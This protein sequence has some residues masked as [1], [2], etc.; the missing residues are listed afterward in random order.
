MKIKKS[1]KKILIILGIVVFALAAS[2]AFYFLFIRKSQEERWYD[3]NWSYRRSIYIKDIP[4]EFQETQQD[5][6]VQIDTETLISEEKL[7]NDCRDIRFIDEDNNTSLRYWIEGGCNTDETQVWVNLEL[8]KASEKIIYMYYGN[9]LAVDNQEGWNGEFITMSSKDCN[10]NWNPSNQ[11][12]GKFVLAGSEFGITGGSASHTHR[13]FD[14]SEINCDDPVFV[15]DDE[16]LTEKCNT[17]QDNILNLFTTPV[18]N[19]PTYENVNFCTSRNGHLSSSSIILSDNDTPDG[20]DHI[21]SLDNKFARGNDGTSPDTSGT[22]IHYASCINAKVSDAKG[23][24]KYLTLNNASRTTVK[25]ANLPYYTIN[26]ISNPEGGKIPIDSIMMVSSIPPLGWEKYSDADGKFLKGGSK[27]LELTKGV[28][29]HNHLPKID[30][31]LDRTSTNKLSEINT[32]RICLLNYLKEPEKTSESSILPPYIT[33]ALAKKKESVISILS[34][35]LGSE[36]KGE[37]LGTTGSGPSQPTEL[38]T[39]GETNP[40]NLTD[41]TPEFTA[42][43]NHPDYP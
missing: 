21:S 2:T 43:F 24:E 34:I 30:L 26:Y 22:H 28:K 40:T 41:T 10:N 15:A 11:F 7:V 31:S 42:K 13:L 27:N 14:Y 39:E 29:T 5:V 19:I 16:D 35:N 8:P 32:E 25:Q 3:S 37:V 12:N 33:V 18:S 9:K 20:W 6:L 36:E 1:T 38:K 23:D 4:K 17:N